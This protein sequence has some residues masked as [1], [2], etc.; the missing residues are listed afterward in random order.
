M[1]CDEDWKLMSDTA[2]MHV[3]VFALFHGGVYAESG[4]PTLKATNQVVDIVRDAYI[5]SI[6]AV[7]RFMNERSDPNNYM[8]QQIARANMKNS[9]NAPF[10][11]SLSWSSKCDL[12]GQILTHQTET[13]REHVFYKNKQSRDGTYLNFDANG[14]GPPTVEPVE[15]FILSSKRPGKYT[16]KVNNYQTRDNAETI[17]FT[18]TV[19]LSGLTTVFNDY[20][21]CRIRGEKHQNALSKMI[22]VCTVEITQEGSIT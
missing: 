22:D 9:I 3:R 1:Y 19:N 14:A 11:V 20:W 2:K 10:I 17:T 7:V 6:D 15:T 21:D 4:N 8:V 5:M 16:F 18:V 13:A 12:D